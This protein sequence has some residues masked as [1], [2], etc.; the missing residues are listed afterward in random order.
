MLAFEDKQ[1]NL[2]GLYME[3]MRSRKI[4]GEMEIGDSETVT[5][6]RVGGEGEQVALGFFS[7]E[8]HIYDI[9]NPQ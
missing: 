9:S 1:V 3:D 7:G 8:I 2:E 4:L 5:A 6:L